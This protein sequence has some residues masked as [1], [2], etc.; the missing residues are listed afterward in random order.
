MAASRE[1]GLKPEPRTE[2]L[3][4]ATTSYQ[5][6]CAVA[7]AYVQCRVARCTT[8]S[9]SSCS[10]NRSLTRSGLRH[11]FAAGSHR[12]RDSA[13]RLTGEDRVAPHARLSCGQK[14]RRI[15]A[16]RKACRVANALGSEVP[17][18]RRGE[19]HGESGTWIPATSLPS[20]LTCGTRKGSGA[21]VSSRSC[22]P[23]LR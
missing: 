18:G 6:V 12:D 3:L 21:K 7:V 17:A 9:T 4:P 14:A 20:A 16:A 22:V 10:R 8:S 23:A 1:P 11:G 19:R 2:H 13:L 5:F 15:R